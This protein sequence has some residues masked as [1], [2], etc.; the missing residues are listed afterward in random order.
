LTLVVVVSAVTPVE[1]N[2][3]GDHRAP[4]EGLLA[5]YCA[6]EEVITVEQWMVITMEAL[7]GV[8][9]LGGSM[10]D[11]GVLVQPANGLTNF[12]AFAAGEEQPVHNR[13]PGWTACKTG[14][15]KEARRL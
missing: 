5:W 13:Y 11:S 8:C 12:P 7:D 9:E 1:E 2:F 10:V 4:L 14:K 6:G 15:P 3:R